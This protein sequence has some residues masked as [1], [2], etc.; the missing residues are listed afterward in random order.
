M[1]VTGNDPE[2]MRSLQKYFLFYS[3][4]QGEIEKLQTRVSELEKQVEDKAELE[5]EVGILKEKVDDLTNSL[6][7]KTG[8]IESLEDLNQ[9]LVVKERQHNDELQEARKALIQET[10]ERSNSQSFIGIKR[11]GELDSKLFG[12]VLKDIC[13]SSSPDQVSDQSVLRCS[14]WEEKLKDPHWHPFKIALVDGKHQELIDEENK[15]L[16]GLKNE[17][18]EEAYLA[19]G[20]ALIELNEYNPSGRYPVRELWNFNEN[21]RDT[22][23]EG[24]ATLARRLRKHH[25]CNTTN[26]RNLEKCGMKSLSA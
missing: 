25:P 22:A 12:D 26:G 10:G 16:K 17:C 24:V 21:M 4:S 9:I 1:V 18:G 7:E 13:S 2:E 15:L 23:K 6:D 14:F 5:I 19:I 8:C 11:M 20:N 3:L